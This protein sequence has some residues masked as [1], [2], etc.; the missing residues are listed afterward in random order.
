[1]I[2]VKMTASPTCLA[3]SYPWSG[4]R[5]LNPIVTTTFMLIILLATHTPSMAATTI[6]LAGGRYYPLVDSTDLLDSGYEFSLGLAAPVQPW[7]MVALSAGYAHLKTLESVEIPQ[8]WYNPTGSYDPENW[9]LCNISLDAR[10]GWD[11]HDP[12]RF[13]FSGGLGW[14]NLNAFHESTNT[15][16]ARLGAG[17]SLSLAGLFRLGAAARYTYTHFNLKSGSAVYMAGVQA[18]IFLGFDL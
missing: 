17:G 18:Q 11:F 2:N 10:L 16:G 15:I 12:H 7:L 5:P 13:W 4:A 14:Y 9:D 8:D 3:K 1:M 6:E